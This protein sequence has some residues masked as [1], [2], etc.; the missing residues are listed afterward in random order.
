MV[1]NSLLIACFMLIFTISGRAQ[2]SNLE[3]YHQ[4]DGLPN[5]LIKSMC[6]DSLGF[7]WVATDDGLAK[8]EGRN[9]LNVT[10]PQM[11]SNNFKYL[12]NSKKYGLLAAADEGLLAVKQS[13][14]GAFASLLNEAKG[15]ANCPIF[16]F[17][18]SL[19]DAADSSVW[20]G[21][22]KYIYCLKNDH[23]TT[24]NLP[25]KN[26]T[27]HFSRSFQ[28]FEIGTKHLYILSQ[29]G[30]LYELN[31]KTNEFDE[32]AWNY[33][34]EPVYA[35]VKFNDYSFLIGC[36]EGLVLLDFDKNG[37]IKSVE[38]LGFSFPV[39]VI[40]KYSDNKFLAGTWN[41]GAFEVVFN[42]AKIDFNQLSGSENQVINDILLDKQKQVWLGTDFGIIVYRQTVFSTPF[43]NVTQRYVRD[44]DLAPDNTIYFSDGQTVYHIDKGKKISEFYKSNKGSILSLAFYDSGLWMGSSAG[45]LYFKDVRDKIT[46]FD[47]SAEGN[48]IYDLVVD[49][50]GDL[51]FLQNRENQVRV[52]RM[53]EKV[54]VDDLTPRLDSGSTLEYLKLSPTAEV[55]LTGSGNN[56]YLYKFNYTKNTFDNLSPDI[57][58]KSNEPMAVYDLAF[59]DSQHYYLATRYG[60]WEYHNYKMSQ[61]NLGAMSN[62][63]VTSVAFDRLKHLW[64][65]NSNGLNHLIDS[66]PIVFNNSDGLPSK[67]TNFQGLIIDSTD[68]FWVGTISGI[69]WGKVPHA[70][71]KTRTPIIAGFEKSGIPVNI[72]NENSF[73]QNSLLNV[74]VATPEY[75]AKYVKYQYSL[76]K[77]HE[78]DHWIN[79]PGNKDNLIFDNLSEGDYILKIK[80]ENKGNYN[81]SDPVQYKFHIFKVWYTRTGFIIIFYFVIFILIYLYV[82]F[83]RIKSEKEKRRL[84]SI[85]ESRTHDLQDQNEELRILNVNLQ[86]AKEDAEAAIKSKDRFFSILAHDLKSPFNTLIG[87]SQLLVHNRDQIP[88]DSIDQVFTEMLQTSE[89]TYKLLQNLLDWAMTQTGSIKMDKKHIIL[90][91][92]LSDILPTIE[93]AAKQKEITIDLDIQDSATV[94]CDVSMIATI[95]RNLLSNAIKFSYKNSSVMVKASMNKGITEIE[96]SDSGIG[97]EPDKISK[98]FA[99]D[100][101][102][103]TPG[104]LNEK[105][106][107][108]G[109]M[110]SY[111]FV[112]KSGGTISVKSEP[113]KGTTFIVALPSNK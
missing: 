10:T 8:I 63:M 94:F 64:F 91:D 70:P 37:F 102:I 89:N 98:L 54:I 3:W 73:V 58:T 111:E 78:A 44:I 110:L 29:K 81:W 2:K 84:E 53:N 18:K 26:F 101:N 86:K 48:A 65:A 32:I 113:K 40:K 5:D 30:Y 27:E 68:N 1:R 88:E 7:V 4:E 19:Y 49:K 103:S 61:L 108:L 43:V 33:S 87:F 28:F 17:P 79:L 23:V 69:G 106:T 25:E 83:N 22:L 47:F 93:I 34:N 9:F 14:N 74:F 104:T 67:T 45:Y 109:L 66:V 75:P 97:I 56:N 55:Y 59:V 92:L 16:D 62:E 99:I 6:I 72:N 13:Y 52:M 57:K 42:D 21:D 41:N 80:A 82:Y 11:F 38:N 12:L 77:N 76:N 105:G 90:H 15:I 50:A 51:W 112:Q 36:N 20:I 60:V 107:G 96:V 71:K 24:Y 85:I 100:A 46:L 95:L 31:P 39:S 35:V